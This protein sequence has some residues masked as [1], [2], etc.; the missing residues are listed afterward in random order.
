MYNKKKKTGKGKMDRY[1]GSAFDTDD[2]DVDNFIPVTAKKNSSKKR[3]SPKLSKLVSADPEILTDL[4]FPKG[5]IQQIIFVRQ[6][7][8]LMKQHQIR[9]SG[10]ET[11][12]EV[13]PDKE[14]AYVQMRLDVKNVSEQL[15]NELRAYRLTGIK[16]RRATQ[17]DVEIVTKLY[18]RSFMVGSDPWSPATTMQFSEIIANDVNIIFVAKKLGEDVGFIIVCL[19]GEVPI[20]INGECED[21]PN[22][23]KRP[24]PNIGVICG[25]GTD[26]RWQRKGIARFLG[27]VAWDYL[28]KKNLNE[29]RCE[30]YENN[31]PSYRLI[32]SLHFEECGTKKYTF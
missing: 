8:S 29:L 26:P 10:Q 15:T 7:Q 22:L 14:Y 1:F 11:T 30:V 31:R 17:E 18:N 25:L 20:K 23:P 21:L 6:S 19:E 4:D 27:V 13:V 32:K 5:K 9:S 28:C 3:T 16:T 2:D 12:V 24:E